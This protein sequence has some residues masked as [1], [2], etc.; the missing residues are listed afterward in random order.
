MPPIVVLLISSL[1]VLAAVIGLADGLVYLLGRTFRALRRRW[2]MRAPPRS[3]T[4]AQ[5]GVGLAS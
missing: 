5:R 2:A 1:M 4:V 3:A